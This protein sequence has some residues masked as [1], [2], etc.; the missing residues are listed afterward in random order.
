MNFRQRKRI[1]TSIRVLQAIILGIT[2]ILLGRLYKLQILDYETY[3]PLSKENSLRQEYVQPAR[4]LIFDANDNLLVDNEPIYT[5]TIV[6]SNYNQEKNKLLARL[7]SITENDLS[8]RITEAQRFSWHRPSKLMAEVDFEIFSNIQEHIYELPG[9]NHQ[10]ESKRHYPQELRASHVLGYL[11]EISENEFQ[12]SDQYLLGDKVGKTGMEWFYESYLR[13]TLGISYVKVN[14]LGQDLGN[15][16]EGVQ[17]QAPRAGSDIYTTLNPDLQLLAEDLMEGK[18]GGVV[19]LNPKTGAVKAMVSSP[20]YDLA[21]LAGKMDRDYWV[22]INADT[23]TPLYNRSISALQPPGSTFKPLMALIGL[24]LGVITPDTKVFCD[25]AYYKGRAYKCTGQHGNQDMLHAIQNSCNTYFFSLMN[26]IALERGLNAW[27]DLVKTTGLGVK[28][29]IDIPNENRGI[30]PDS[31]YFDKL[32]GVRKWGIG[33]IINLGVGQGVVSVSP[34]QLAVYGSSIANGGYRI[35]PHL[36]RGIRRENQSIPTHPAKDR[37]N[38]LDSTGLGIVREGM[39]RVVTDGSARWYANIKA[40]EVAGKTGTS[41]NPH[42]QDHSWFMGFAPYKNPE[43]IVVAFIENG[44]YGSV[45]AAPIAALMM[46]KYF[47]GEVQRQWVYERVKNFVPKPY[48]PD[49]DE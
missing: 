9:I 45:I 24:Q 1:R 38:W 46:E 14:A 4:G 34:L 16:E 17:N 22:E 10:I 2:I 6:P 40:A 35:Q 48:E 18:R 42:G 37:I 41:Q 11:R 8:E 13:G 7:L 23:T 5:I 31:A 21:R 43:I 20:F 39:R 47:T 44:G 25:G 30:I 29:N 27:S 26:K 3:N 36:V 32:F 12:Q 49:E 28:N 33:D 19:A 15:Y